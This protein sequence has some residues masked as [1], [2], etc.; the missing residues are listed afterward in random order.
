MK[1]FLTNTLQQ[2]YPTLNG[3]DRNAEILLEIA[4]FVE[5]CNRCDKK[6]CRRS[7]CK[8]ITID[9][10]SMYYGELAPRYQPNCRKNKHYTTF[11]ML[12]YTI[13]D[14]RQQS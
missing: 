11:A 4:D 14:E 5:P 3:S 9:E 8:L 6:V 2:R 13:H 10:I 7:Y 1:V 12:A